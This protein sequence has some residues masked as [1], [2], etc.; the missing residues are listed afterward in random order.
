MSVGG[1]QEKA[2]ETPAMRAL[3]QRG[4]KFAK[5]RDQLFKPVERAMVQRAKNVEGERSQALGNAAATFGRA[6]EDVRGDVM[7]ATAG[8]GANAIV[9]GLSDAAADA[10]VSRSLGL[11]DVNSAVEDVAAANRQGIVDYGMGKAEAATQGFG[12]LAELSAAQARADAEISRQKMADRGAAIGTLAAFG[13]DAVQGGLP[14]TTGVRKRY[15]ADGTTTTM[16][17]AA[18]KKKRMF[19]VAEQ[20]IG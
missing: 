3:A 9:G 10:G 4:V 16:P 6:A 14:S 20:P 18:P 15:N 11:T 13:A 7:Q 12:R 17:S 5:M 2:K 19:G 8:Q 1:K